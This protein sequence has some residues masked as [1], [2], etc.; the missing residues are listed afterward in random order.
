[1]QEHY[2]SEDHMAMFRVIRKLY[3]HKSEEELGQNIDQFW[4]EHDTFGSRIGSL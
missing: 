2:T 3:C 4:I 1:M